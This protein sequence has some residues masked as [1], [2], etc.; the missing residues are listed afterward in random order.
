MLLNVQRCYHQIFQLLLISLLLL[1][2]I[3]DLL[4][5]ARKQFLHKHRPRIRKPDCGHR[6]MLYAW[7]TYL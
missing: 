5:R 7:R 1:I 2:S 6:Q 4:F 3:S